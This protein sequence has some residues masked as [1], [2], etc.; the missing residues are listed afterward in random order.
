MPSTCL[1]IPSSAILIRM[2]LTLDLPLGKPPKPMHR[3]FC[4]WRRIYGSEDLR[5]LKCRPGSRPAF[6][7]LKE[8]RSKA[9][10]HQDHQNVINVVIA[11]FERVWLDT[12]TLE[13]KRFIEPF[14]RKNR[15]G[16]PANV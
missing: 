6:F 15:R 10:K 13:P 2:L 11:D 12:I 8:A 9:S 16:P 14:R 1:T 4:N 7:C 5:K 3:A